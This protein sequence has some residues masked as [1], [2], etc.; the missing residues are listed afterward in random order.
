MWRH[1]VNINDFKKMKE[2]NNKITMVTCYDYWSARILAETN[3]DSVLVGDSAAMVMHGFQNTL[4]A[5]IDLMV[6]H[7]TAVAK[8]IGDK[9]VVGDMPFCSYRK[10]LTSNIDAVQ[11][12]M[13][14][15][16]HAIKLEGVI[17]NE[18][19]IKHIVASGVPVMGHIGLTPQSIYQLGGFKVQGKTAQAEKILLQQAQ[20]LEDAGCFSVVLECMPTALAKNI[21]EKIS[22]PT[23]GIGAGPYTSGQILVLHDLLGFNKDFKPKFVKKYFDG[24]ALMQDA[25][26][27]YSAEVKT[28]QFPDQENVY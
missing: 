20:A 8:G 19:L 26:N 22:I 27:K 12:I 1:I 4:P 13:H 5:T 9:F 17:G 18:D 24:A 10:D 6:A 15:G 11:K 25:L 23:I 7:I 14:A 3:I 21:T 16:A 2:S 28:Q